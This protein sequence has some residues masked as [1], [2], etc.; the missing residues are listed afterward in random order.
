L[1][2]KKTCGTSQPKEFA[3]KSGSS[4]NISGYLSKISY[5]GS[6]SVPF[7]RTAD[8]DSLTEDIDSIDDKPLLTSNS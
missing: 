8:K 5:D 2:E 3:W 1:I 6:G 4:W 7:G